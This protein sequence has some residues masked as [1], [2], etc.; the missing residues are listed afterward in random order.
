MLG[1][2]TTS[3]ILII[4][5]VFALNRVHAGQTVVLSTINW[6]P[7]TGENLPGHGFISKIV[8]AAF[9]EV[10]YQVEFSIDHGLERCTKLRLVR[11]TALCQPIGKTSVLST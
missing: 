10:G 6:P 7:Y 5:S 9:E 2:N 4:C 8:T 1:K 3:L 11:F